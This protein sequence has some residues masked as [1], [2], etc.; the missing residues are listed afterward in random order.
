MATGHCHVKVLSLYAGAFILHDTDADALDVD[1]G[2][3]RQQAL[4][5]SHGQVCVMGAPLAV[6]PVPVPQM[7]GRFSVQ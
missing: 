1:H 4:I 7:C 6:M 2:A 5:C 3:E